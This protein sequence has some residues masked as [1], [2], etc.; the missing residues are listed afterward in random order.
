MPLQFI[1]GV[2]PYRAAVFA[3]AGLHVLEDLL[4]RLPRRYEDRDRLQPIVELKS[5]D[6]TSVTGEVLSC[7]LRSTRRQGFQI[8][9]MLVG[10]PSGQVR[11]VF[12]NQPFLK[13]IF[14]T[15]QHVVLFGK[16]EP[17][18][19]GGGLQFTNPQYEVLS[20]EPGSGD[21]ELIHTGRIVPVHEKLGTVT[22]KMLR[23]IVHAGLHQLPVEVDDPLPVEVRE[24]F[25]LPARR[26]AF[27]AAHFPE[28][29]V[30][31]DKLNG[32]RTPG[33]ATI[34]LRGVLRIPIRLGASPSPDRYDPQAAN[35]SGG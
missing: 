13:D 7:G 24:R 30:S 23:Q 10:D 5:G 22:P 25:T 17:A 35:D 29:G 34:D 3:D 4:L 2:G 32:F 33:P 8:F 19:A 21:E 1:K 18:R 26:Q 16:V 31:I 9:E 6:V 20:N 15:H 12:L 11:A 28:P 27:M 14:L